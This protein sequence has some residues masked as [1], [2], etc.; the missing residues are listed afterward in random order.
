MSL[1]IKK[2]PDLS[3]PIFFYNGT[4]RLRF[5]KQHWLYLREESDG[6]LTP[7][8]GVTGTCHI[9]DKSQALMPWAVKLALQRTYA[10]LQE[11]RRGD[12]FYE[13]F[14]VELEEILEA[15]KKADKDALEDAGEVGHIAHD[16][17]ESFIKATLADDEGRQFELLAKL[18]EDDR[19]A[20]ACIAAIEWMVRHNVRWI[21]TERKVFNRE[22]LYAGTLDGLALVDSCDDPM[23]CSHSFVNRLSITDWKTSNYLYTEYLLQTAAYWAAYVLEFHEEQIEDR[24]IIRLGKD[25]AEFDPWHAEGVDLFKEDFDAFIHAQCLVNALKKIEGRISDV[26]AARSEYKK[27]KRQ[28]EKLERDKIRCPKAD[29]YKGSRMTKCL[30]DGSQCQACHTIYQSKH[31]GIDVKQSDTGIETDATQGPEQAHEASQG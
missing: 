6:V 12:G 29:D 2:Y 22:H 30:P 10:L 17:I 3:E 25:D 23:C 31:G 27:K 11:H 16:W 13:I 26:K 7:L 9:I 28:A 20:N 21:D 5:S 24:W 8:N 15:A 4:E 14:E 18:P 19:A 1:K